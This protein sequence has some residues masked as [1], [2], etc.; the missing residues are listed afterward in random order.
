MERD[1]FSRLI[2]TAGMTVAKE[3]RE[4]A[5]VKI[6]R[7]SDGQNYVHKTLSESLL[8]NYK[9]L[10]SLGIGP[11][12]KGYVGGEIILEEVLPLHKATRSDLPGDILS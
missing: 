6:K 3:E 9:F 4:R 11:K 8:S 7:H 12:V 2:H 5:I 10:F 1:F